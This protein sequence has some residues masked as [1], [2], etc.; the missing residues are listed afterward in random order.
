MNPT[1]GRCFARFA[2][3][4]QCYLYKQLFAL[5]LPLP[6]S[7]LRL[8]YDMKVGLFARGIKYRILYLLL[9]LRVQGHPRR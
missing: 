7:L 3:N 9:Q 4:K 2:V 5:P 1:R 6:L 8:M